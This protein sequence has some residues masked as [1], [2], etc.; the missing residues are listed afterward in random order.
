MV[1][2]IFEDDESILGDDDDRASAGQISPRARTT[3]LPSNLCFAVL[4][5]NS[6]VRKN[7]ERIS[8]VHLKSDPRSFSRGSHF[9]ECLKFAEELVESEVD[10][11]IFDENL[12]YGDVHLSGSDIA[13]LARQRGF[14]GCMVRHSAQTIVPGSCTD[15]CFDGYIEKT[16][17]RQAFAEGI[18]KAWAKHKER[19]IGVATLAVTTATA[20]A[21]TKVPTPLPTSTSLSGV[22]SRQ[23]SSSASSV[24]TSTSASSSATNEQ[25]TWVA[26]LMMKKVAQEGTPSDANDSTIANDGE[27][28]ENDQLS[29]SSLLIIDEASMLLQ[30]YLLECQQPTAIQS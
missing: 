18:T 12:E 16:T 23:S 21:S 14:T 3:K 20:N 22:S 2:C 27:T 9:E 10:I 24:L 28:D 19:L 7:V 5:D 6:L 17:S 25:T 4:D 1:N 15:S 26:A 8:R 13:R 29:P 30:Q 11:A